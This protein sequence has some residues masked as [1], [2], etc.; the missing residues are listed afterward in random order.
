MLSDA[1]NQHCSSISTNLFSQKP[2]KDLILKIVE[3]RFGGTGTAS[4][5]PFK[6]ATSAKPQVAVLQQRRSKYFR[7]LFLA[8]SFAWQ[9]DESKLI[10]T[11]SRGVAGGDP[12]AHVGSSSPFFGNLVLLT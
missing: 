7:V 6:L 8:C 1:P 9:T 12:K 5:A 10:L 4:L 3:I 2:S 11:R